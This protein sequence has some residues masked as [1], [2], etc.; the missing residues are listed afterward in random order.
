MSAE[1]AQAPV[2]GFWIR[3]LAQLVDICVWGLATSLFGW[4]LVFV[5]PNT[6]GMSTAFPYYAAC[7]QLEAPPAGI[8]SPP[9]L[10][11][12]VVLHCSK[13]FLG[14]HFR[15]EVALVERHRAGN[16]TTSR[17]VSYVVGQIG[18]ASCRE[19]V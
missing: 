2:A 18:R 16:V 3:L 11:P 19:R 15:D 5:A 6:F 8:R 14:L 10:S 7:R 4:A 9:G 12:N 17:S 1:V 13:S